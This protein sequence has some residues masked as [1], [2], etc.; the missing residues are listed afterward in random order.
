MLAI[1]SDLDIILELAAHPGPSS[2]SAWRMRKTSI[3]HHMHLPG[4]PLNTFT[5]WG[6]NVGSH[7]IK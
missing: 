5:K 1:T 4:L 3:Q 2:Q 7:F 6:R